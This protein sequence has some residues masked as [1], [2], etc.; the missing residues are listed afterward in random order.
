MLYYTEADIL[1]NNRALCRGY[2]WKEDGR[3]AAVVV[4]EGLVRAKL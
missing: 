1:H 4:Q 3:L 2:V